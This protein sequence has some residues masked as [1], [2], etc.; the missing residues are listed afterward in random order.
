MGWARLRAA[1]VP[2]KKTKMTAGVLEK[3]RDAHKIC[4]GSG[5]GP[6]MTLPQV[7][8]DPTVLSTSRMEAP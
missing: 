2:K 1:A 4:V 5:L 3:L 7:P 8:L 6:D